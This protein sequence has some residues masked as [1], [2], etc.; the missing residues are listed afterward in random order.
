MRNIDEEI[1]G[2]KDLLYRDII[3]EKTYKTEVEKLKK[4]SIL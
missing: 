4:K 3:D 1:E 2:W